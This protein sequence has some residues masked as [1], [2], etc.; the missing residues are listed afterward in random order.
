MKL[1][2]VFVKLLSEAE[3]GDQEYSDWAG[4]V[5]CRPEA[6]TYV[7]RPDINS[8]THPDKMEMRIQ[9]LALFQRK[10]EDLD[11]AGISQSLRWEN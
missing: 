8:R 9:S 5:M 6:C 10:R 2:S 11:L 1:L 3:E 7:Y 4:W